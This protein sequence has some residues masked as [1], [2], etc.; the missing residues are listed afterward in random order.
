MISRAKTWSRHSGILGME[1][2]A[3]LTTSSF[4]MNEGGQH[5]SQHNNKEGTQICFPSM[6]GGG[7]GGLPN[8]QNFCKLAKYFLYAIFILRC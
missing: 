8:S 6:E 1:I 2:L 4:G 3:T 5:N 7:G